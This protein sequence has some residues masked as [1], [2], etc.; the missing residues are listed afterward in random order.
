ML[1]IGLAAEDRLLAELARTIADAVLC[2]AVEWLDTALLPDVRSWTG[3]RD[4]ED[5]FR[6]SRAYET[7]QSRGLHVHGHFGQVP[8][9]PDARMARATLLLF[10]DS[11]LNETVPVAVVLARDTDGK[12][13]RRAGLKQ[14]AE[15]GDWPFRVLIA[16]ANPE[17]EAWLV[18]GFVPKNVE[19]QKRLQAERKRLGFDPT[20]APE[21]L[22]SSRKSDREAK[23]VERALTDEDESRRAECMTLLATSHRGALCGVTEYVAAARRELPSVFA[24]A[25]R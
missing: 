15:S 21:R 25:P 11:K 4:D 19:E 7:A 24:S 10:S 1:R 13:E 16:A 5:Y 20:A 12:E 17:S 22:S 14:A 2:E 8:G 6:L 23:R 18:A 9:E 3:L